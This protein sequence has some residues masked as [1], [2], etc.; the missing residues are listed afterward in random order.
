MPEYLG[1]GPAE[2]YDPELKARPFDE[3]TTPKLQREFA[4]WA[5]QHGITHLLSQQPLPEQPDWEL[6]FAG[7]DPFL[8]P[9]MSRPGADPLFVYRRT[10]PAWRAYFEH[11][12]KQSQ[13]VISRYDANEVE[14]QIDVP[15]AGRVVLRD[16]MF[17]GWEVTVDGKPAEAIRHE[18]L[19]RA[20]EVS[21]GPHTILWTYRPASLR[22]GIWISAA[23]ILVLLAVGHVRFWHFS[24]K[25]DSKISGNSG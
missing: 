11:E 1:L 2:Y 17:P 12:G 7:Y 20:V 9:A 8:H 4:V 18:R 16:L 21:P 3:A 15:Q 10:S 19:F 22:T 13:A 23:A 14:I 24:R 6:R 25:P 5:S